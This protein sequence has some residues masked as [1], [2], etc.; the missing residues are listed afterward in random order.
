L[1]AIARNQ[2]PLIYL[3]DTGDNVTTI[4]PEPVIAIGVAP[5]WFEL[6]DSMRPK[7]RRNPS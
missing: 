1:T 2:F 7:R 6:S 3:T 5:V 4:Q